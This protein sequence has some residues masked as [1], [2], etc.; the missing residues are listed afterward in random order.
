MKQVSEDICILQVS[1]SDYGG[2]AEGSAWKLFNSYRNLG[3]KSFLAVGEKHSRDQDVLIIPNGDNLGRWARWMNVIEQTLLPGHASFRGAGRLRNM[4]RI[5]GYPNR[6]LTWARGDEDFDYPGSYRLLEL[7]RYK[8]DVLHCHNLHGGF[9]DL[10]ALEFL[11][12]ELPV[13]LNLRDCWLLSGHC[14]HSFDCDRWKTGCGSC[15]SL[16]T[17]PRVYRDATALNWLTKKNIYDSSRLYVTAPS[18][19]VMGKVNE[20]ILSDAAVIKRVIPNGVDLT[21]FKPQKKS[22]VRKKLGFPVDSKIVLF[23]ATGIRKNIFR[24]YETMRRAIGIVSEKLSNQNL[25]FVAVG[26]RD[27]DTRNEDSLIRFVPF[28]KTPSKL[29]QYYQMADVYIHATKADTFSNT[30]LEAKACGIPVIATNVGALKEQIADG[31][32]GFLV[33]SNDPVSMAEKVLSLLNND[34]LR[35]TMGI[36]AYRDAT[37]NYSL[38]LQ[39][40]RFLDWY[41]EVV[42]DWTA[43]KHRQNSF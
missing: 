31:L 39:V 36:A 14:A 29:A 10:R 37:S 23:A 24:D 27:T 8:P 4:V 40:S 2:G 43:R 19:W 13:I 15:P 18:Q 42:S 30:T 33:P 17:Y 11:S 3:L 41:S 32:T 5:V 20:S 22:V 28:Q 38:D 34:D 25:I 1:A 6:L 26:E 16:D 9:F 12:K 35:G 21:V 7:P